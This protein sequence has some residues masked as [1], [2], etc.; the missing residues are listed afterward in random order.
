[1]SLFSRIPHIPTSDELADIV[2]SQLKKIRVNAPPGSKIRRSELSLLKTLYF[3]QFRYFFKELQSRLRKIVNSFPIIDALHPFH[4]ELIDILIGL[5][6]LHISLSRINN[7][8]DVLQS[9]QKSVSR[10]LGICE[11]ASEAKR[12]RNEALGR[13]GSCIK[14]LKEPL[15]DLIDIKIKLAQIP[16][17][18][19]DAPTIAF[20]GPPNAGK[21]SFVS[22]VST[23]KPEI[24][25]YPFTTKGLFCGHRYH[26]FIQVQFLDTPGLL[27][28]PLDER[29]TI[30]LKGII[31]LKHIADIIVFLFDPTP[32]ASLP[33]ER[34]VN[35]Q[36]EIKKI[37]PE[38]PIISYINK[39]DL[40]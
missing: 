19:L 11:K 40:I 3:R 1:M 34:Q 22:I 32:E 27:D 39:V 33:L 14:D 13:A 38:T 10:K 5:D 12:I 20:A 15:D 6:R 24:A 36:K 26:D 23:G 17:F 21:S 25:S 30:E 16:D 2:Y 31:A 4:R 8:L 18:K 35:L 7:T 9:I 29:N 28:R 37:F